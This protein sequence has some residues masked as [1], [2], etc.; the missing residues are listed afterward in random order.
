[1]D[2]LG[3]DAQERI[4]ALWES[5]CR[6]SYRGFVFDAILAQVGVVVDS[7]GRAQDCAFW[8]QDELSPKWRASPVRGAFQAANDGL[9]QA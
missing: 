1:M 9:G 4:S 6:R 3:G 5:C 8:G 2:G 7:L